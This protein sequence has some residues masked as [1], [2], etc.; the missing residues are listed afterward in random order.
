[1]SDYFEHNPSD[2]EDPLT[3]PTW[4]VGFIGVVMLLVVFLGLTALYYGAVQEEEEFK[5]SLIPLQIETLRA[6]QLARLNAP[7]HLEV[8][9]VDDE[10][11]ERRIVIPIDQAID[12]VLSEEGSRNQ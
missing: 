5:D 12:L 2:H 11:T 10:V 4:M 6:E 9:V 8:T 3:A 7:P 1:M